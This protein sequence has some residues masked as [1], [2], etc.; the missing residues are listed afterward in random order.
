MSNTCNIC[1]ENYNNSSRLKINCQ[2]CEYESCRSCCE[3]FILND[4]VAKCMNSQCGKEWT[5]K[6]LRLNFTNKFITTKYK[7]HLEDIL[8]QQQIALLPNT[9]PVAEDKLKKKVIYNQI[10]ERKNEIKEL[11]AKISELNKQ[12][13][14]LTRQY[15]NKEIIERRKFTRPCPTENCR[16]FLSSQ[17]KCGLCEKW[18]C[19]HCHEFKG[20]T[21]DTPHECNPDNIES[22]KLINQDSKP[23][24]NCH[25]LI[26]KINGCD[27]MFCTQCHVAFSW[28]TGNITRTSQI[29]NPHYFE[30][31]RENENGGQIPRNPLDIQCGR[32]LDYTFIR[33]F[34]DLFKNVVEGI[35]KFN[36][37]EIIFRNIR[38]NNDV[39]MRRYQTNYEEENEKIRVQYLLKE[40]DEMRFKVLLQRI[41]KA[42]MKNNEMVQVFQLIQIAITDI[43][44]LLFDNLKSEPLIEN[45]K[46]KIEQCKQEI[47]N[48][49]EHC[50]ELLSDIALTYNCTKYYFDEVLTF[51]NY[52]KQVNELSSNDV[53]S[54]NASAV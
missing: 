9:Q 35:V 22:A 53:S 3:K 39:Y 29:H 15:Y 24:P 19:S 37:F 48:L 21:H 54:E 11:Q 40:I 50:N 44:Y 17:W 20:L 5:R 27:Q 32:E 23:C 28:R 30:W 25:S 10:I 31:L 26:F 41:N 1:C 43:I 34:R 47:L 36:Y 49:I 13:N 45:K 7:N 4:Q 14:D 33:T 8:Y 52:Y 38:H 16:G 46:N 12:I 42:N 2:F 18:Y 6:F 51:K